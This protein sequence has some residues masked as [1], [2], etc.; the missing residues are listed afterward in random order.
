LEKYKEINWWPRLNTKGAW[1]NFRSNNEF[2]GSNLA[3]I[4]GK[5]SV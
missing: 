1:S 4:G 3:R 5:L 2:G